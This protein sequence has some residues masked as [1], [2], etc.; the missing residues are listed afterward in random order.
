MKSLKSKI[1]RFKEVLEE[2]FKDPLEVKKDKTNRIVSRA[3]QLL[4]KLE[5]ILWYD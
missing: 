3:N 4:N 1:E 5:R 2:K